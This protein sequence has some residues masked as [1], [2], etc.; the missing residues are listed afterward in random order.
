MVADRD[1]FWTKQ[2]DYDGYEDRIDMVMDNH[3]RSSPAPQ[4]SGDRHR[5]RREKQYTRWHQDIIPRLVRPYM[6]MRA[7]SD[8]GRTSA[9]VGDLGWR[10][11]KCTCGKKPRQLQVLLAEWTSEFS[12]TLTVL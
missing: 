6:E 11:E 1:A 8:G 12:Y 5:R 3:E 2:G 7:G 10:G 9:S 4:G